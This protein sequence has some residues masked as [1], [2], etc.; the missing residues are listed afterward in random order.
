MWGDLRVDVYKH[1]KTGG[2]WAILAPEKRQ[3]LCY[4]CIH[5]NFY[6]DA[7]ELT[8]SKRKLDI[9]SKDKIDSKVDSNFYLH[10]SF[11]SRMDRCSP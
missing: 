6:P 7:R 4:L 3:H 11:D 10:L 5:V 9:L 8:F 2:C 1:E